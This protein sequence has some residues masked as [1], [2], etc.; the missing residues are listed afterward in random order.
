[1][2]VAVAGGTTLR[3][4][5]VGK[6]GSAEEAV[7]VS[8][9]VIAGWTGRN[10]EAIE[11]HIKELEDIGV[12]R[13][14]TVPLFY[15]VGANLLTTAEEVEALGADSSGEVEF[16][17]YGT[18]AGM[19]IGVGSDHTDRKVETYSVPVS[20]QMCAK[21]V[22]RQVW[23]YD[24]VAPHF[25]KLMLRSWATDA[26]GRRL[27]QEGAVTAMRTPEDLIGRYLGGAARLPAGTAMYCGT[28]AVHGGLAAAP[29]FEM[30]IE[31]PVLGRRIN[32][33]YSVKTLPVIT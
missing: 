17:L 3:L 2:G 14:S 1:M 29:R 7:A 19:L 30:E 8:D 33:A 13:P 20:K 27:Y 23:R 24:D 26:K 12:P 31:D 22:S 18:A 4:Q 32:H 11:K 15:R 9:L 28:L 6:G 5:V 16:V 25:D 21:P 10:A